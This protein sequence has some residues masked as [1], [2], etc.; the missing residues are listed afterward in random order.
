[1]KTAAKEAT[2]KLTIIYT[3]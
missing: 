3:V 2:N 1:M